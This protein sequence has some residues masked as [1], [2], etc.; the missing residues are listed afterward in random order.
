M[1]SVFQSITSYKGLRYREELLSDMPEWYFVMEDKHR[2]SK[3]RFLSNFFIECSAD[4]LRLKQYKSLI[5]IM[6]DLEW[7]YEYVSAIRQV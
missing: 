3:T 6:I 7:V 5:I 2:L 1:P 4:I